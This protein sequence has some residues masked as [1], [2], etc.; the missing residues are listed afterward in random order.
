MTN[1]SKKNLNPLL[2]VNSAL[3]RSAGSRKF[4]LLWLD[5]KRYLSSVCMVAADVSVAV[6]PNIP[7]ACQPN[8]PQNA[9]LRVYNLQKIHEK[10]TVDKMVFYCSLI[11]SR[12]L[13]RIVR[14]LIRV[15]LVEVKQSIL[16]LMVI[17]PSFFE[18]VGAESRSRLSQDLNRLKKTLLFLH[19]YSTDE[20]KGK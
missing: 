2:P 9:D 5:H 13:I 14:T 3:P 18:K 15:I 1:Y 12:Q 7:M 8:T 4:C 16:F 6:V 17:N 19:L 10:F 11:I 20:H